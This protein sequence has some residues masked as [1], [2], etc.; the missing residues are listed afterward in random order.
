MQITEEIRNFGKSRKSK[1][2]NNLEES[3][4]ARHQ[5]EALQGMQRKSTVMAHYAKLHVNYISVKNCWFSQYIEANL[6]KLSK[7]LIAGSGKRNR[8]RYFLRRKSSSHIQKPKSAVLRFDRIHNFE[9]IL[10]L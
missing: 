1:K 4:E 3:K 6:V 10:Q 7:C 8:K 5:K 2:Q 9:F